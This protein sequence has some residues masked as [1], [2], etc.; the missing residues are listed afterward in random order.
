MGK[1]QLNFRLINLLVLSSLF[2]LLYLTIDLWDG[3]V[4]NIFIIILPF[5]LAFIFAYAMHP[6]LKW[7]ESKK[8]PKIIGISLIYIS[9][10][11]ILG[12]LIWFSTPLIIDQIYAL[13]SSLI[14]LVTDKSV[15]YNIDLNYVQENLIEFSD[16][17]KS[18]SDTLSKSAMSIIN[19]FILI[20]TNGIIALIVSVYFLNGMDDIREEIKKKLRTKDKKRYAYI[21]KLDYD[22]KTYFVGLTKFIGIQFIEYTFIYYIVGHP[23]FLLM[24]ILASAT[25]IIPYFGGMIANII[26]IITA[27][28]VSPN[29]LIATIF[30]AI[31]F[32]NIDGYVISPYIYGKASKIPTLFIIFS[33]FALGKLLGLV[34]VIISLPLTLILVTTYRFYHVEIEEKIDKVKDSI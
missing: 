6:I 18:L 3:L 7:F 14:N 29:L 15:E 32:P 31:I 25:T 16:I 33:A 34:G 27:A 21:K 24:G 19:K 8:I 12:G 28:I 5:A 4:K 2:Y 30:V 10:F 26:A 22:I 9:C 17:I 11:L 23:Y 13:T 1:N 20:F